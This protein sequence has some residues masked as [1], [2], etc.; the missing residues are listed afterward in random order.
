MT[1]AE[2]AA[3]LN[4]RREGKGWRCLCPAHDDQAPSLSIIEKNGK[5]LL[6]CRAGCEQGVVIGALRERGLWAQRAN[7]ADRSA[8]NGSPRIVATYDYRDAAGKVLFQVCRSSDKSFPQRRRDVAN[9]GWVWNIDGVRRVLYRLPELIAAPTDCIVFVV[10]GEKDVD[11]LLSLGL[12]A[13]C[14]PG[15]AGKWRREFNVFF[16]GRDVVILPDNDDAGRDH[17]RSIAV[18]LAPVAARIRI[19]ELPGLSPKGDVSDWLAAGGTR[20]EMERLIEAAPVYRQNGEGRILSEPP[21]TA[22]RVI[23][24]RRHEAADAGLVAMRAAGVEFYQRDRSLV[25]C[26]ILKAKASN[27][28]PIGVPSIVPVTLPAL[29]RALGQSASWEKVN[30]K[31]DPIAIDPPNDVVEQIAA[32]VGEWPFPPLSGMIGTPTLRP[33]GTVLATE[34]YDPATGLVL[35]APPQ[36]PAILPAPSKA[37]AS[38]ALAFVDNLLVEFPFADDASHSVALSKL[39]TPVLRGAL[40]PAAPLHTATAP[41][42]GTGKSYLADLASAIATGERCAVI[43][44]SPKPEETEKRLIGAALAGYPIIAIDN[45]NG[46]LA[47][48]FLCQASE[49]PLLQLRRLGA[50]DQIRV[51]NT[52]TIFANG[53]NLAVVADLV[54]RTLVCRLDA[55]MENPEER[56]FKTDPVGMVLADRGRYVA[57][58]LTIA[59]A[60]IVAGKPGLL[61]SLP[62]YEGW[63]NLVRSA[64][65]W[66][67]YADPVATISTARA[68]D[69]QR[70]NRAAVFS[71]WANE[72]DLA[73]AR[74]L[75]NELIKQAEAAGFGERRCPLLHAAL[76]EVA[77][78]SHGGG[79]DARR[80]GQWLLRSEN[81]IVAGLKLT[82]DRSDSARPRWLLSRTA[83]P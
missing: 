35:L 77:A 30:R 62:S 20:N 51:V 2:I 66:L 70:Q 39:M 18:N 69:Q 13:T 16:R 4:G 56:T 83:T 21:Q 34:G 64:L 79:I 23:P 36:M 82:V 49:R 28:Q 24:G 37:E 55:N 78:S 41:A 42:A 1:G 26:C 17:A 71:A 6:T 59:R 65:V 80:L 7:G 22:I 54:R 68:E 63:S 3:A 19:V 73:P 47:G 60:Y 44:A 57:A 58:I 31:R 8:A 74:Y 14:N 33:D 53:N 43:A 32:M 12:V 38:E 45:C 61:P 15:G 40:S 11:R 27:G 76:L 48:D 50:S 75:T 5:V 72:L 25:R 52:F 29:G 46:E 9:G 81:S 10:E 67:G